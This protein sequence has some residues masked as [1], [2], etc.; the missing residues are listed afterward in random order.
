MVVIAIFEMPG[1]TAGQYDE[2]DAA[3]AKADARKPVG[4]IQHVAASTEDGWLVVDLWESDEQM[5]PFAEVL[6]PILE[7]HGVQ[8]SEPRIYQ[9]HNMIE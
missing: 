6:A 1:M 9:V 5:A 7:Q 4:R 8:P 3:L 2:V